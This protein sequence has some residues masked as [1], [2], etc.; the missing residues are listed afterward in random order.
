[1]PNLTH[2]LIRK[3]INYSIL[4]FT[5]SSYIRNFKL[6]I[7]IPYITVVSVYTVRLSLKN[8]YMLPKSCARV[9]HMIP[10]KSAVCIPNGINWWVSKTERQRVSCEEGIKFVCNS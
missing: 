3:A 1:M 8:Y 9:F 6:F 4:H 5:S 10:T 2:N 7:V